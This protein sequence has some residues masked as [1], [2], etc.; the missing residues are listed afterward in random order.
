MPDDRLAAAAAE[1]YG[2]APEQFTARRAELAA[3]ARQAG[4]RDAAKAIGA[5]RRPTRAAWVV[6]TLARSDP[7]APG[8]LAELAAALSAAQRA[9]QG[10]RLREL[11]AERWALIDALTAQ[12]LA[13]AGLT[14]PPPSL[15]AEVTETVSAALS[16]PGVAAQFA[17]G[18][19]T[20][21]AQWSGFGGAAAEPG[22]AGDA[23][24]DLPA[25]AGAG[26]GARGAERA[27]RGLERTARE[28]ERT[29]REPERTARRAAEHGPGGPAKPAARE[30]AARD[31]TA[32][33]ATARE[34]AERAAR[35]AAERAARRQQRYDEAE[36]QVASAA[37]AAAEANAAEDSLE[38]QVRD[39]EQRLTRARDE[40]AV[41]RMRARRAEA[42]ERRAR[43]AFDRL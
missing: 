41:T 34:A 33:E 6:N 24:P 28:P 22:A 17:A 3:T 15:R 2:A 32:R 38:A 21:A 5:L 40:L 43:Q 25:G 23:R 16:D 10:P 14:D 29:A 35:E 26:S 31:A 11:S 1:L 9:A 7:A 18:R 27:A 4:D 19:L 30:A 42:A 12:A 36:Q 39:L 8:K 13:A 20:R 37:A